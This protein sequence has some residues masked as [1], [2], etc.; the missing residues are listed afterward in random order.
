[1]IWYVTLQRQFEDHNLGHFDFLEIDSI[2]K[3]GFKTLI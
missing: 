3:I 1:M 2:V